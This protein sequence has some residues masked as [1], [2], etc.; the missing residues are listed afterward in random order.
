MIVIKVRRSTVT[1]DW[2]WQTGINKYYN[3]GLVKFKWLAHI[4]AR[5][6]V[7][8]FHARR[9]LALF[10]ARLHMKHKNVLPGKDQLWR[11]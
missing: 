4:R 10:G 9:Q 11:W 6:E 8:S 5:L 2:F 1:D 3:S 7:V